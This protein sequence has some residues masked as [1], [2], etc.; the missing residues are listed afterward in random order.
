MK[1]YKEVVIPTRTEKQIEKVICD[2]CKEAEG[3]HESLY[4]NSWPSTKGNNLNE[5]CVRWYYGRT[6]G[7][8]GGN[9]EEI[10]VHICSK[11][12]EEKL[13]P[14]LKSEGADVRIEKW[15]Y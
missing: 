6:Y 8:D 15:D 14:W 2:L 1:I 9:G 13:I 7:S 4:Q 10:D 11:C 3:D 12:F 5:T